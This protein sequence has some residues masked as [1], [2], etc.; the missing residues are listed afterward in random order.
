MTKPTRKQL[1]RL[2]IDGVISVMLLC[3]V[4]TVAFL[5]FGCASVRV[6]TPTWKLRTTTLFKNVELPLAMIQTNGTIIVRGLRCAGDS[7]TVKETSKGVG[8][9]AGT[10]VKAAIT[11]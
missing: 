5:L 6:E 11:K 9:I 3:L 4:V 7:K 1:T 2:A 8:T 10:V